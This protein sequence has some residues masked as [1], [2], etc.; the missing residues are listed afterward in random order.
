MKKMLAVLVGV[1][2]MGGCSVVRQFEEIRPAD[3][4]PTTDCQ[5]GQVIIDGACSS[6][7]VVTECQ[8]GQTW[9]TTL[10]VCRRP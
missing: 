3:T 2:M 5:P 4:T 1:V 8:P 7:P 10:L 9:D 6:P